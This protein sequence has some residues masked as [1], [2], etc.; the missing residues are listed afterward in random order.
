MAERATIVELTDEHVDDVAG[1]LPES[2]GAGAG[3]LLGE[4]VLAWVRDAGHPTIVTDWRMTN[5]TSSRT[6]PRL[7]FRPTFYRLFRGIA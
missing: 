2:R 5:L 7:G 1:V 6:W 3:R 4:R